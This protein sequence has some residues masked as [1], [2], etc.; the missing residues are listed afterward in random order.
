MST[1]R[2]WLFASALTLFASAAAA[3]TVQITGNVATNTTWGPTGTV[4]GTT[5][6][7]MNSMAV[8]AGV[9]L[10]I[11]PGVVVKFNPG[12]QL[13]VNGALQ[14]VGTA[15]NLIYF[16]SIKDDNNPAGDTNADGNSTT[17]AVA[18]WNSIVF[19]DAT[20][21]G[22]SNL[23]Y[24]DIRY[25]G[26]SNYGAL[27]FLSCSH[28][29][30]DCVIRK[31]SYG[32]DCVGTSSPTLSNTSIEASTYT[33]V[34]I[35]F[36][37]NPAFSSVAFSTANN[38]YDAIGLRGGTL[39]SATSLTKRG[40]TVG[41][42]PIANV[43]YV[44]LSSLTIASGGSLTIS[45]G[46]VIKPIAAYSF[47][48]NSGGNLTMNGTSAPGD[49]ITITSISDDNYGSPNDTNNNGSITA[50]ARGDWGQITFDQGASG[51]I[52]R[53]RLKFGTNG[54]NVGVVQM[55]NN[56][57]GVASTL[58]SD[59]GHGLA[60]FGTSTPAVSDVAINNCSSTPILMSV[61]ANPTLTNVS[62]LANAI[63][64]I[65][66]QGEDVAVNSTIPQRNTGGYSN[67][68]YYLMNG[69]LHVLSGVTLTIAPGVVIKNQ[70]SG[71]GIVCDGALVADGTP[72]API[73]FTSLYDDQYGNPSDTNGDGA[74]TTPATGNWQYIRFTGTSN[75]ATC[76][77]DNCRISYASWYSGDSW[78]PGVWVTSANPRITN[79]SIFKCHYGI[80]VDGDGAPIID[81]DTFD[82]LDYAPIAMSVLSDP[83]ISTNNTYTTNG[84]N[85][86]ALIS[87]TLSAN[88]R[89][90]Y[91]PN[92]G[93]PASPTFAYLP[94]G[95]IT[96]SSG[97]TLTVDPQVVLKPSGAF[98]VFDVLGALNLVGTDA[99]ANRIFF[100]SRRDD[101]IAGDTT[102]TDASTP[103]TGDWGN[104]VYEDTAVDAACIVRNV[105]F[106]F[107][108]QGQTYGV[109]TTNSASPRFARLEF[110][111]NRTAFTFTGTSQPS[112]DS[113][114]ILN[115]TQLPIVSSLI[116]SPVYGTNITF[117]NSAYLAL[118]IL[119][120]TIAQDVR[121]GVGRIGPYSNLNYVPA[122]NLTIAFGAKWTIAPGVVLKFGRLFYDP[123]GNYIDVSGAI[124]A[125]GKPDSLI[126]FTSL[127][128]DAFGQDVMNDG[129]ATQPSPGQWSGIQLEA[130]SND[131]AN[132]FQYCRFRYGSYG[133]GVLNFTSAGPTISNCTFTKNNNAPVYVVGA[134][135]PTFNN[136]NFDSTTSVG[137][138]VPV[139]MSLVSDPVFNNC[140]FLGN[141]YT[142]L[143]ILNESVAQD[144]LWK[145]RSVAGRQ[146]MP[147]YLT[148]TLTIG[149]GATLTM[150][151]GVQIKS[152][153]GNIVVQRA[154][155][156]V[157]RTAP[158]SLIV[159]TSYRDD[160]YGGD[161]NNDGSLTAPTQ[162]EAGYV[163]IDG[164]AIDPQVNFR[165]CV[166]RYGGSGSSYGA[167]RCVNSSPTVDST[168]FAY[169][170]VGVSVEGSSNPVIH[171]SSIYGNTYYGIN[172]T[173]NAFCVNAEGNWWGAASGPNDASATADLC[174][175]G[176][177]AGTGD[178][179][180]NNVDYL[181][182][183]TSGIQNPLL[184]DVSL[185]GQVLAY[186]ASLVL[187]YTV[188]AISLTPL[189]LLVGDVS[190]AAGVTAFDA[191]L[192][193]QYVAG[194][195]KAF[196]AASTRAQPVDGDG[197]A[198]ALEIV[199]RAKGTFDVSLGD[200]QREGDAWLV[201]VNV[202]GDAPVWAVELKL[203]GGAVAT[204]AGVSAADGDRVLA[205]TSGGEAGGALA[206][207]AQDPLSTGEV[208]VLRFPAG[209]GDF[210][211]PAIAFARVNENVVRS[212][213][214]PQAPLLSF[215]SRPMPN[216]ARG[217]STLRFSVSP[218]DAGGPARVR[219]LDVAGRVVRTLQ[220]GPLAAGEHVLTWDL[221]SDS[222]RPVAAGLYFVRATLPG[223]VHSQ[224]L[225]VVR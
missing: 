209:E 99:G 127:A 55:T 113:L 58:L 21:D 205:V 163:Q 67:I 27:R 116:S 212:G 42:N 193:L 184:G 148:G 133:Q 35:D 185:N 44:L 97:V 77:L 2:T 112:L 81:G 78:S 39:T 131:V 65:G 216:P 143:G 168:L 18:D 118:G 186:D 198:S 100:T 57:I 69:A 38:G 220:D 41:V 126:I 200:A 103:Q 31:S 192:I 156:A 196:P 224:R 15:G 157:G 183:A 85:A 110:F 51:S 56:N 159:F 154:I 177:N 215:L 40:A 222:G 150:Q 109:L 170:A 10:T 105:K 12:V 86:L 187:Q 147:F 182:F 123:T 93:N 129:A 95:Q 214:T 92:V 111:Q 106:Q 171:G 149:L 61:A 160:F 98:T 121:T 155:S 76:I 117:A 9:T 6:R 17:P 167:L 1:F 208:A 101:A 8:N 91:R 88:A 173:G 66:L 72:A 115:C 73:V 130:V 114:T 46:V 181:P 145:I 82:N 190:G 136:C 197:L 202:T 172:N 213:A 201:P 11:Q 89:I 48:V 176:T 199:K 210:E 141:W 84:Y 104:I 87:E 211:P 180:S 120:E 52:Q 158:E 24:C 53:C 144:V 140:Q 223:G 204:L 4:V 179:V 195:I 96:I 22:S 165:N 37:A 164:T 162:G 29:V 64:A 219:V 28:P 134:S 188:S 71:G 139:Y 166:F 14:A 36:T 20:V 32:V 189:Q 207:A 79:S 74:T 19:A 221:S 30:S 146:N 107:G 13:A 45:P 102:P 49:S 70:A 137:S 63:T 80:R 75:D 47:I 62:F 138:G 125:V 124:S 16:T 191:S 174:G 59:C 194:V 122:G 25:A 68:T 178:V 218:A 108:S 152:N 217:A 54:G 135:T 33:P 128:D 153:Y 225:I 60:L 43:T 94:T 5:F 151:P 50:P 169:N 23:A 7:I 132:S 90:K 142:A 3:Q 34:V 161:S 26:S 175:L 119:G 83:Q 203:A 206:L